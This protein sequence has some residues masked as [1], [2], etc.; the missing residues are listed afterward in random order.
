MGEEGSYHVEIPPGHI[1][2][3]LRQPDTPA[4]FPSLSPFRILFF[5]SRAVLWSG[6]EWV[7]ADTCGEFFSRRKMSKPFSS[8]AQVDRQEILKNGLSTISRSFWRTQLVR[9]SPSLAKTNL[10]SFS[11]LLILL[12]LFSS[13]DSRYRR[14]NSRLTIISTLLQLD[15]KKTFQSSFWTFPTKEDFC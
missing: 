1:F 9:N 12:Q 4:P 15:Q 10:L 14:V 13:L 11:F 2:L 5:S 7:W 6:K 3:L 8:G